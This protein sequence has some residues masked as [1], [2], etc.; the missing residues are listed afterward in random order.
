MKNVLLALF[1]LA[2]P[3]IGYSQTPAIKSF[4]DK[5]KD[6]ENVQDVK[7]QGWLLN[8]ASTFADEEEAGKLL[9]KITQLRVLI[10]D[11]G[12]LVSKQEYNNL[13]KSVRKSDF[14]SLIQI[15]DEGQNIE[16][17][18]KE[19][20]DTIT[21]VLVVVNGADD[22]VLLSLEGKLKFSDLN[23]LNIEVEGAEHF[24]KLP[25]KKKDLPRA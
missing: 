18:I 17:L 7:L 3:F 19:K 14:E 13:M 20:G 4:Y 23:D 9:Q 22:F 8:I 24:Q 5:Y 25:E 6:M 12:N 11:E 21:D 15:K 2:L 1:I 10:M 16:F